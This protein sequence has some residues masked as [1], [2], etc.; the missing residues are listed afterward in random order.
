[1]GM[2]DEASR[3][4]SAYGDPGHYD[5]ADDWAV[6]A[7]VPCEHMA[8]PH[9]WA[10]V[11]RVLA[12][13]ELPPPE[14]LAGVVAWLAGKSPQWTLM[15]GA[16][17]SIVGFDVWDLMPAMA[18]RRPPDPS[19]SPG[20][21]EIGP[22]R[23]RDEFLAA[24]GVELAPLVTDAHLASARRHHLVARVDGEA[25]GCARVDVMGDTAHVSAITV[26]PTHRGRGIGT[27]LTIA[28][29]E[30]AAG[31]SDLVW[32]H[33]TPRS[34]PLYA[35]LGYEHVDTHALLTPG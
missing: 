12:R 22:A 14:A 32:L 31:H 15:V 24:Y 33:C 19:G 1:M 9:P 16:E 8:L 5:G 17:D 10:T 34:G 6:V 28:A 30:R 18:L 21:I 7:G 23:D 29:S 4:R 11:G 13:S 3:I 26:V 35:R 20:D 2:R 27:R 25:V